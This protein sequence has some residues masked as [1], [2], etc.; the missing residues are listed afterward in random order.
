[1]SSRFNSVNFMSLTSDGNDL[2]VFSAKFKNMRY[3]VPT[4]RTLTL[5]PQDEANLPGLAEKYLGD[6]HLW[7]V[8][9]EYNGLYDPIGE[10]KAGYVLRIPSRSALIAYLET[11]QENPSNVVL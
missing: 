3:N 4:E 5:R 8:L 9:L 2:S 7:W 1:M 11:T 6:R 10:I